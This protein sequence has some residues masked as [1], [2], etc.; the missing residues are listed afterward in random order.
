LLRRSGSVHDQILSHYRTF[1]ADRTIT[2]VHWTPG[3]MAA[4]LP[5]FHIAKI[6]PGG[7][8][9]FWTF[10]SIGAWRATEDHPHGLEF[11]VVSKSESASILERLA[12]T[13]FY[14]A[15]PE[16]QR[17]AVGHTVPIGEG[18]VEG[19]PLDTMLVSLPY[20][21]GPALENCRLADRLIQVL[22]LIPIYSIERDFKQQHGLA[23]L[24]ARFE[25]VPLDYL[26]PF[27]S[28]VV[29]GPGR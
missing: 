24:E 20:L 13:A 6:P 3:P 29:P 4:R 15:G 12:M 7:A 22:W 5:D 26:D 16:H 11:V 8:T 25:Q 2:E 18:W 19:S 21:W 17:L 14:Q 9:D 27:R 1:W 23:A 28:A 10:A